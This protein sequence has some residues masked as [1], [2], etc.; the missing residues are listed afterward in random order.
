MKFNIP[1]HIKRLIL[2]FAVFIGLFL[3]ARHFL[4]PESFGQYGFYRA[5]SLKDNSSVELHYAGNAACVDCHED[6]STSKATDVHNVIRCETCHGAGLQHTQN[7]DSAKMILPGT[8]EFCGLC[9]SM[10][11][12]KRS[13]TIVQ[14]N[15]NVHNTG[16]NCIECHNPHM[17]WEKMK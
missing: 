6:V 5:N 16:K 11:A 1:S 15:L 12:A 10:N 7:P 14:I 17:P 9:H 13:E 3:V 8:R 4:Y 2:A